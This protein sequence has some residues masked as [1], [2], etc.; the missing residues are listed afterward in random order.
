MLIKAENI[1][2]TR[3]KKDIMVPMDGYG[4]TKVRADLLFSL[5]ETDVLQLDVF[6]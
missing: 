5:F 3:N 4:D 6:N 2:V 1:S